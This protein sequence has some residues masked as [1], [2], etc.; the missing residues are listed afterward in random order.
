MEADVGAGL[1]TD[2][3]E[4]ADASKEN[5]CSELVVTLIEGGEVVKGAVGG[6]GE[7]VEGLVGV[8]VVGLAPVPGGTTCRMINLSISMAKADEMNRRMIHND[9]L[10]PTMLGDSS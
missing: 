2:W 8:V 3:I 9:R 10:R 7:P 1:V 4:V 5:D 6:E